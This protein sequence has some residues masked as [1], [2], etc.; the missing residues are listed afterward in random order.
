MQ[1]AL[2]PWAKKLLI[3]YYYSKWNKLRKLRPWNSALYCDESYLVN[4]D[5]DMAN[6]T[7]IKHEIVYSSSGFVSLIKCIKYI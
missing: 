2:L 4:L 3:R 5:I 7:I 1:W 6:S